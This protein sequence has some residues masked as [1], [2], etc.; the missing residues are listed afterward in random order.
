MTPIARNG[1]SLSDVE[2]QML[3][4]LLDGLTDEQVA[5]RMGWSRR[6]LQRRLH[7]AMEK[8][9]ARSRLQAG[10]LLARSGFSA[11]SVRR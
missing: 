1:H 9:G 11:G 3:A 10:Y 8:L 6:T 7:T 5:A 2:C 4:L